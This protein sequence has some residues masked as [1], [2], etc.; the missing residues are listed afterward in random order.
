[1][2]DKSRI[3]TAL[4]KREEK[5]LQRICRGMK[6]LECGALLGYS[7]L[8]IAEVASQVVSIDKHEGYGPSTLHQFLCN[9]DGWRDKIIPVIADAR[10]LVPFFEVDRYFIDLD[11]TYETTKEVLSSIPY[12]GLPVAVH[13]FGRSGCQGVER[14]LIDAGFEIDEVVDTLVIARRR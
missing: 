10:R 9:I 13:D 12:R 5:A 1:M 8:T 6:V 11:G 4:S 3:P 2:A 7:T 14:A